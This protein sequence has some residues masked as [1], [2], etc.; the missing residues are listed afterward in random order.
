[1]NKWETLDNVFRGA[2]ACELNAAFFGWFPRYLVE[3]R[4]RTIIVLTTLAASILFGQDKKRVAVL[5]FDSA[6]VQSSSDGIFGSSVD[7]GKS[8]ANLLVDR[9]VTG[10]AY[11]VIERKALDKILAE[12]NFSNGERADPATA[13]NIGKLLSVNAIIVGT[14]TQ[15][16]SED[17]NTNVGGAGAGG[18]TGRFGVG[19]V[20]KKQSKAVVQ[21]SARIVNVETGEILAVAQGRGESS[22]SSASLIGAGGNTNDT[23]GGAIDMGSANFAST[24]LGEAVNKAVSGLAAQLNQSAAK[25]PTVVIQIDGLVA[26]VSGPTLVLNVGTKAGVRVGDHLHVLR[27]G[28]EIKDPATGN[29]LRRNDTAVG[30][31]VITEADEGSSVGTFSGSGAAIVGDHVKK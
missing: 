2:C 8:I 10:G 12:Q 31:V 15:F 6:A 26:D 27:T 30:E 20:S 4:M 29:V 23:G 9:L 7:V 19:G 21:L 28:R 17:K 24:M 18:I 5:D 22:R 1:M 13:A 25:L 11:S 14:V 3:E 16:G